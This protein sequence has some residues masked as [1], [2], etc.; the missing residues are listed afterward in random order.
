MFNFF[1]SYYLYICYIS[2]MVD[3]YFKYD[4][5]LQLGASNWGI[6][7]EKKKY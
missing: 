3:I 1:E 6:L 7:M 4:F 5:S 2:I